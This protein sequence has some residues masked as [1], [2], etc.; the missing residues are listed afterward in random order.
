MLYQCGIIFFM[1]LWTLFTWAA[2]KFLV[3]NRKTNTDIEEEAQENGD[4]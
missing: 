3:S 1:T 4:C 2:V